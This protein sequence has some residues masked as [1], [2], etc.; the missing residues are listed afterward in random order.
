MPSS[1]LRNGHFCL[2]YLGGTFRPREAYCGYTD[3]Q[4]AIS[5]LAE[6]SSSPHDL[7]D[8]RSVRNQ[9]LRQPFPHEAG[10]EKG[11]YMVSVR[12]RYIFSC[13]HVGLPWNTRYVCFKSPTMSQANCFPVS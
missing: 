1:A 12:P 13:L 9:N 11:T 6:G 4:G 8:G 3:G 7:C 5:K 10:S 2:L